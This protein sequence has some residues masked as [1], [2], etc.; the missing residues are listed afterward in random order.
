MSWIEE[1]GGWTTHMCTPTDRCCLRPCWHRGHSLTSVCA[2][3]DGTP[4]R[5]AAL[6]PIDPTGVEVR[7]TALAMSDLS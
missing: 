4:E 2:V 3:G 6:L 5:A 7:T 1:R